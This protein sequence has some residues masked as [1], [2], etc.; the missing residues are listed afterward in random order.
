VPADPL[1]RARDVLA[2]ALDDEHHAL[3]GP[4]GNGGVV[5]VNRAAHSLLDD[6]AEPTRVAELVAAGH[7]P[8]SVEAVLSRLLAADLVHLTGAEPSPRFRESRELTVWLHVTNACNLACP[9]CY[10]HKS[11][12][13]MDEATA[14]ETVDALVRSAIEHGFTALRLKYAGGEASLNVGVLMALHDH[15]RTRCTEAGLALSAVLLSNGV[16]ISERLAR[17]LAERQIAVMVSLDGIGA[18]HDAQR[19]TVG[20]RPS[21]TMVERSIDRLRTAGAAPHLSITITGRNVAD[22]APVVR[23]ALEREL[24]FSFNFFRDN[25]C[26]V[27]LADLQFEEQ[28]MI[29]GLR[30]AFGVVEEMLPPWSVLGSVLDR[31][32][33]LQPRQK[34][35]GVGDDYVVVDQHGQIAQCHMELGASLGDVRRIDPVRAVRADGAPIRNLLVD[36]KTG[37]RDCTWRHWCSGGCAVA[38]FAATGRFDVRS[39]NC[40]IYKTIYPEAV[41]LE[42]KRLLTFAGSHA[43]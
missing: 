33:L 21:F 19:P 27:G 1:V 9:Y 11:R 14:V 6:L 23:F 43:G 42:G 7:D 39:P 4:H 37:C 30:A 2:I 17:Q 18:A 20:G 34:A 24:T 29:D 16:A 3:F 15:A 10:V 13:A 5:V 40:R 12:E 38:T 28:A 8:D 32:Q 31:G 35:C 41:R 25:A 22:I 36:A 26:S